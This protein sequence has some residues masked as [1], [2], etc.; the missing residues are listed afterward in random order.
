MS[1]FSRGQNPKVALNIG[2]GSDIIELCNEVLAVNPGRY[3][4]PN[5]PDETTCPFCDEMD[6]GWADMEDINHTPNCAYLL[7]QKILDRIN[8]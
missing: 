4:N 8:K 5:G 3:I 7:A 6:Q 1:D 2:L